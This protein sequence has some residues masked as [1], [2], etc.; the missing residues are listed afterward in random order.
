MVN[1]RERKMIG[2]DAGGKFIKA[3]REVNVT[4]P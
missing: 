1:G 3:N 2:E 4:V